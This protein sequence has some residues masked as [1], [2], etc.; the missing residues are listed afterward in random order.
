MTPTQQAQLAA[1]ANK[2]IG[3]LLVN[4]HEWQH[5]ALP[6]PVGLVKG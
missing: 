5:E 4:R 2:L 3:F 1:D 6:Q